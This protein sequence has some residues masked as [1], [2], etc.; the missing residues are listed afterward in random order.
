MRGRLIPVVGALAGGMLLSLAQAQPSG[1]QF[2]AETVQTG[3]KGPVS[4]GKMY[5]G[6][7]RMRTEA[8]QQGRQFVRITDEDKQVEW[9]LFPD[10][11]SYMERR[12][13]PGTPKRA[14]RSASDT[15]PC[16]AG[17]TGMQCTKLGTETLAGRKADKWEITLSHQGQTMKTTQ[18]IDA[19]RGV[20]LR[21]EMGG[22]QTMELKFVGQETLDGRKVEKWE[23]LAT[24][25]N[26]APSKSY[27]WYDPELRLAVRQDLPGGYVSEFKNIR[28]GDQPESLFVIPA[29]YTRVEQ[30]A[31]PAGGAPQGS[32]AP[33][34][35][36]GGGQ[37][38]PPAGMR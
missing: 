10:Q 3:P 15:N 27:Q 8:E 33:G 29:G 6:K 9:I 13:P 28:V 37:Q 30:P 25:P 23:V 14:D 11:R 18:W 17:M 24:T 7:N 2:S 16:A 21:Q 26:Q 36:S 1:V 34:A 19:E 31:G 20:P 12:A 5:V 35:P 32:A 22:G 38:S 4:T